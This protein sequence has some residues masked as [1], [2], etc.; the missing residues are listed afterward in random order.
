MSF[1]RKQTD[2][3]PPAAYFFGRA[4]L[5]LFLAAVF[6]C[7]LIWGWLQQTAGQGEGLASLAS[8]GL[9]VLF[10][11]LGVVYWLRGKERVSPRLTDLVEAL[12]L[13]LISLGFGSYILWNLS[14]L[15]ESPVGGIVAALFGVIFIT[16]GVGG[17]LQK[18]VPH[19][20]FLQIKGELAVDVPDTCV[21][22]ASLPVKLSLHLRKR[23]QVR[24]VRAVLIGQEAY[25]YR[26]RRRV[27]RGT[28]HHSVAQFIALPQKVMEASILPDDYTQKWEVLF[29]VP[30]DGPPTC[31]GEIV[32]VWWLVRAELDVPRRPNL[33][34]EV[35]VQV[36]PLESPEADEAEIEAQANSEECNLALRVAAQD[37]TAGERL[38][39]R[40]DVTPADQLE[41]RGV[42]VE[43]VRFERAGE[44]E[45]ERVD[46]Q[47]ELTGTVTLRPYSARSLGFALAV[48]PDAPSSLE[49]ERSRVKWTVR[50]VVDVPWRVDLTVQQALRIRS[51]PLGSKD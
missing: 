14:S 15:Q 45:R 7:P 49:T 35:P 4:L 6:L 31:Q 42:R 33:I 39:G 36:L 18:L 51:V 32:D 11:T 25:Y 29:Q 22:G 47:E 24:E 10:G 37:V 16:L 30:D 26:R 27:G 9:G 28:L 2:H 38:R 23:T 19:L 40:L 1:R 5:A 48:P 3:S 34:H 50:G 8:L 20:S 41:A 17:F 43:L 21:P 44:N 12:V 46:V 13:G